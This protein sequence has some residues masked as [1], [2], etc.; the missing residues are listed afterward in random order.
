M[1]FAYWND[2][3]IAAGIWVFYP[4][5]AIYYYGASSGDREDRKQMAP[6]LLQWHA[7]ME[8]KKA[9]IDVY[10]MLG[11]ADPDNPH[12]SLVGVTQFKARF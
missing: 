10:D 11:V 12:D 5:R 4:H 7:I 3:V 1:Y 9:N 8:A 2:R 6:Y